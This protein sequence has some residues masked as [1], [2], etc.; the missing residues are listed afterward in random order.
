MTCSVVVLDLDDTLIEE[1]RT[2]RS[3]FDEVARRVGVG[4]NEDSSSIM[5]DAVRRVWH[6]GPHH[7]LCVELGIASWEGLWATFDGNHPV[8]D[9]LR[10]WVPTY[11]RQAW[12]SALVAV[13]LEGRALLGRAQDV[14]AKAQARG[15]PLVRGAAQTIDQLAD[16]YRLGLL[17][18]G[19]SDIQRLKLRGAGL[20]SRFEVVAISGEMGVGKPTPAAFAEV[21]SRLRAAPH[22]VVMVGDSWERDVLGALSAGW[23]AVWIA[24]GTPTP[25]RLEGVTVIESIE[26][27]RDFLA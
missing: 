23:S 25:E 1:E 15:H 8:L 14:F 5:R 18:N 16:R 2:A 26:G 21:V 13:G 22:D 24:S 17:T 20:G 3:S 9:D 11:R 4:G 6:S 12:R 27:L 10:E 7:D 19:P